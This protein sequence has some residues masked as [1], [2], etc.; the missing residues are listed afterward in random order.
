MG[1]WTDRVVPRLTDATLSA[2]E[3]GALREVATLP[4][5]GRVIEVGFGS[6][7]NL[8]H[9]P[10]AVTAV[11]AVEPSELGWSR[12]ASRREESS[13]PVRRIGLDGRAIGAPDASYDSALVTFSL[14]TVPDPSRALAELRRVLRPGGVLAFLEHGLSPR[15][16]VARWQRRLDPLQSALCGGCTLSRDVPTLVTEAGFSIDQLEQRVLV[17][18]PPV[19]HP[20]AFGYLGHGRTPSA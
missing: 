1:W 17:P 7:L 13:L 2:P 20:W 6:G 16:R 12:S 11:D 10:D 18:A 3:I 5:E 9:L 19:M 15:E 8:P 4:V 14:C